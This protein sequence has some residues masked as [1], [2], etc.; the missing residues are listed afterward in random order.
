MHF[1]SDPTSPA[2]PV[3]S[4]PP[5]TLAEA[6]HATS[7]APV[8]YFDAP[9]TIGTGTARLR[10]WD[11]AV[12]GYDNPVMLATAEAIAYGI[13]R[14]RIRV[15]SLGT[16]NLL[17][18]LASQFPNADPELVRA[19]PEYTIVR[20]IGKIASA[21]LDDPPDAASLHAYLALGRSLP[22]RMG[23]TVWPQAT[24]GFVRMNPLIRPHLANGIWAAPASFQGDAWRKLRDLGLVAIAPARDRDNP[25]PGGGVD[26]VRPARHPEPAGA[27]ELAR[28]RL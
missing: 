20:D 13:P 15:I 18:P 4:D 17:Q 26:A 7:T 8:L 2:A 6:V 10:F 14:E 22:A 16:G 28:L 9:A 11:G 1:R 3:T 27:P 24:P 12:G 19:T 25:A 23:A 5:L 21:V